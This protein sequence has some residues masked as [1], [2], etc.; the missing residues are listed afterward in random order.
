MA[1]RTERSEVGTKTIEGQY[2]PVRLKLARLVSSLLN[3]TWAMFVLNF[4][5]FEIKKY[6]AYDP[7]DEI[8]TKTEPI[9]MLEF[10]L[11]YNKLR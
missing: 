7:Y 3:G 9:R 1:V 5:V 10:A 2:S 4:P 6:T 8:P 11:P